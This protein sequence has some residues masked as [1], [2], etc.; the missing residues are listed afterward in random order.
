MERTDWLDEGLDPTDARFL[1]LT[2]ITHHKFSSLI[3]GEHEVSKL[4]AE[5]AELDRLAARALVDHG[6]A[7]SRWQRPR[8]R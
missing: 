2:A 4:Y 7:P 6:T 8:A 1:M 5:L 3:W